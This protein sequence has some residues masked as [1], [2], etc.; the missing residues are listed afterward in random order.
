M[1][2]EKFMLAKS[3]EKGM[4]PPRN[5]PNCK[6]PEDWWASEKFDGYRARYMGKGDKVFLS[7]QQK[8]FNAPD[9]FRLAMPPKQN[10]DGEL[11][12]GRN[13]FQSMGTV[14]KK[15]PDPKEWMNVKYVVYDMPLLDM[16]FS[17]RIKELHTKCCTARQNRLGL[18]R[19]P[20]AIYV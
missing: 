12:I 19:K 20:Y 10:L 5:D 16:P 14:R 18:S 17:E 6:P 7:R 8:V 13:D 1:S 9:W 4:K 2:K 3:F 15:D 11:W